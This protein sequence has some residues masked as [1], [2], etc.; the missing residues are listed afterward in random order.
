M[1]G[2]WADCEIPSGRWTSHSARQARANPPHA[3]FTVVVGRA[4]LDGE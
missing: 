4:L 3:G 2:I 1:C